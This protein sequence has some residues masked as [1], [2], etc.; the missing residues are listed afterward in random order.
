ML[1]GSPSHM[2]GPQVGTLVGNP[3]S[4]LSWHPSISLAP[5]MCEEVS[6]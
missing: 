3:L 4:Q 2:K 6:R 5:D 1:E